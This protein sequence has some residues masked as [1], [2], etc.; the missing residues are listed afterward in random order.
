MAKLGLSKA[1]FEANYELD[2]SVAD[3]NQFSE[4]TLNAQ[5]LGVDTKVGV[6]SQ[7]K[8]DVQG[9]MTEVL[10]WTINNQK[11]YSLLK[12]GK[13]TLT[14]Y[15]RYK[16]VQG[17]GANYVYIKFTWT[18]SAINITPTTSFG[19]DSKIKQ[20]WYAANSGVAGSGYSDIH[21]N[22]E[23]VGTTGANDK[24]VFDIKNALVD[25][26]LSTPLV[27]PYAG[28][29][30]DL[31]A[32]FYFVTGK[33]L[34]ASE[35]GTAVYAEA[36][37]TNVVATIDPATGIITYANNAVAK[38]MLN[39][40]PHTDLA[41]TV[42]AVIEVKADV[43]GNVDVPVSNS[44]FNVK[45]LRPITVTSG[46]VSFDDAETAGSTKAI[47][48]TFKD[49]RDHDFTD[50]IVTKGYNYFTY[51]GVKKIE[52]DTDNGTTDLN[53]NASQKLK[54][55]T[56]K[57]KFDYAAPSAISA[58]NYGKITYTNN[59]LTVGEFHVWFPVTITYDWGTIK[60]TVK[61]TIAKT[62]SNAKR[63]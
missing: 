31:N 50:A 43:C 12:S 61:A 19:N 30:N 53:G 52:V 57:V 63:R 6:V 54:D 49:W 5:A 20:Y 21:G 8:S 55:I 58:G 60:T 7:T 23:V 38:D 39:A 2:G 35:D 1:D 27:A 10:K 33:G 11:A 56:S 25:N 28:L 26:K 32:K 24:Y 16:R 34:Y 47:S 42:T 44:T 17:A 36:A 13:T 62:V 22:V 37:H 48:L 45:F 18:P 41:N 4:P 29:S 15:V 59:G 3:A 9:T 46:T 14:T 40:V 51:Y